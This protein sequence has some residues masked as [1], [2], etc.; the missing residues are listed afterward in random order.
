MSGLLPDDKMIAVYKI[1]LEQMLEN[2]Q[3]QNNELLKLREREQDNEANIKIMAER[4]CDNDN[5]IVRLKNTIAYYE[6]CVRDYDARQ[7]LLQKQIKETDKLTNRLV[8][9]IGANEIKKK[10][11]SKRLKKHKKH[12]SDT[13][14]IMYNLICEGDDLINNN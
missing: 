12:I 13:H 5:E 9:E 7:N 11:L 3:R 4:L 6:H 2:E 8:Q 14:D 1:A 10:R